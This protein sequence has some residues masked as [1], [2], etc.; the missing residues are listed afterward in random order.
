MKHYATMNEEYLN[1]LKR[2][3]TRELHGK[4]YERHQWT[5]GF[6]G[7]KQAVN[8]LQG[9]CNAFGLE[10]VR[11]VR[12]KPDA[13]LESGDAAKNR[14]EDAESMVGLRQFDNMQE[15]MD[16]VYLPKVTTKG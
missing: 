4:P 11:R 16:I 5:A 9:L 7:K 14:A 15:C 12:I 1:L 10:I 13:Y 3:I 2:A 6:P 8:A